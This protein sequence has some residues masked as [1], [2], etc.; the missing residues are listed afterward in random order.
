MFQVASALQCVIVWRE[1]AVHTKLLKSICNL[2]R[3][4]ACTHG[5][6]SVQKEKSTHK[7]IACG[8]RKQADRAAC[9]DSALHPLLAGVC[10]LLMHSQ[11][12]AAL[13]PPTAASPGQRLGCTLSSSALQVA[14]SRKGFCEMRKYSVRKSV[15]SLPGWRVLILFLAPRGKIITD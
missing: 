11:S 14:E 1:H 5:S 2:F 13:S 7:F 8:A 15:S 9:Q 3:A 10:L 12:N 6:I 4:F